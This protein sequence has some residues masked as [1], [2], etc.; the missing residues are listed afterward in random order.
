M[1]YYRLAER[2]VRL[3][4]DFMCGGTIG[5]LPSEK[6]ITINNDDF[7]LCKYFHFPLGEGAQ[8]QQGCSLKMPLS[9]RPSVKL[10]LQKK[11]AQV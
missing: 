1:L 7:T 2:K 3:K 11:M 10:H 4:A 6:N 5:I 8:C 9:D